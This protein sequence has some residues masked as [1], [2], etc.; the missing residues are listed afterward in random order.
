VHITPSLSEQ[1]C[2]G[3]VY[4]TESALDSLVQNRLLQLSS[5]CDE[6]GEGSY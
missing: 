2:P 1:A 3:N 5:V 4:L 6:D